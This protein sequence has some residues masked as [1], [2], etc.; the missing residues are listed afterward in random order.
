MKRI[1]ITITV[2]L[3][4]LIILLDVRGLI[5]MWKPF[6]LQLHTPAAQYVQPLE[7]PLGGLA[8]AK[9]GAFSIRASL[10]RADTGEVVATQPIQRDRVVYKGEV[11]Y[12]LASFRSHIKAPSAGKYLLILELHDASGIVQAKLEKSLSISENA[13]DSEFRMFSVSH[14]AALAVLLLLVLCVFWIG[15]SKRISAIMKAILPI[16]MFTLML[17]NEV[18][19]HMYWQAVG[20]WSVST[21]LMIQ[22]CGLSILLLPWVFIIKPGKAGKLLFELLYFWGIG[23]ALQALLTPD[24]GLL[25]F[26]SYKYFS[27]F[28]SH[29]LII[30]LTV[31]ASV[32]LPYKI[33]LK[34]L[35]RTMVISNM[36][37]ICIYGINHLLVLL[38]PYEVGNYFVLNYPPVTGSLVDLFVQLFGPSPWYFIGFE[39]MALVVF[40]ILVL[41]WYLCKVKKEHDSP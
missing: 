14:F 26:P 9:E 37:I 1:A 31:Y 18:I 13:P 10:I 6:G 36:V 30:L 34:S 27:F 19:Y 12:E 21:A 15:T 5:S 23:G 22:M 40:G 8:W 32:T 17:A 16:I 25:G 4:S 11:L 24:I 20:A 7:V 28:I 2:L 3:T 41:P 38:P 35:I 39:L 29:G 33:S